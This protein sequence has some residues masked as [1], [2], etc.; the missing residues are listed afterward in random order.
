MLTGVTGAEPSPRV[1]IDGTGGGGMIVPVGP[2]WRDAVLALAPTPD[3][4]LFSS[5]AAQ[6]LVAAEADSRQ[7]P[8][9]ILEQE[10][11]AGFFVLDQTPS[12][13][14]PT[15]NLVLRS[16]FIDRAHQRRGVAGRALAALPELL[17]QELPGA[18][19]VVLTVNVRNPVARRL[20]LRHEFADTGRLYRGGSAGPQHVLLLA[21]T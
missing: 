11:A 13:A 12:P 5:P 19:T 1:G 8:F 6:T 3:Q 14:E 7:H 10:Q 20:Y 21:L 15:A 9:V 4:E 2:Q 18:T 17:E 16:F